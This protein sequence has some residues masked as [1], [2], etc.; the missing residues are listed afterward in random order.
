MRSEKE[1]DFIPKPGNPLGFVMITSLWNILEQLVQQ[2][3]QTF[4][5]KLLDVDHIKLGKLIF[6]KPQS[7]A[8]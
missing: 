4:S 8:R 6:L 7:T 2:V 3:N 5:S 1:M